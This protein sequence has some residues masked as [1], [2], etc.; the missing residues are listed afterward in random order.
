MWL[1]SSYFFTT[2]PL[3]ATFT[4]IVVSEDSMAGL[5]RGASTVSNPSGDREDV[6][7]SMLAAGGRLVGKKFNR[8]RL[9]FLCLNRIS[10][11]CC[12]LWM[13]AEPRVKLRQRE[14]EHLEAA[15]AAF[16]SMKFSFQQPGSWPSAGRTRL[17]PMRLQAAKH[18]E[19]WEAE[20]RASM[21]S[22]DHN[23]VFLKM[24]VDILH[25]VEHPV[26]STT[27]RTLLIDR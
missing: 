24:V 16:Q 18:H 7:F 17:Q 9:C 1:S 13:A 22:N 2:P 20:F 4:G 3:S 12:G 19:S 15:A 25:R 10:S 26:I 21:P 8:V 6:T 23:K 27:C 14:D 5:I 11:V